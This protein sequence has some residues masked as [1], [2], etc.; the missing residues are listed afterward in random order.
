MFG[1]YFW[2]NLGEIHSPA[3]LTLF[4]F[5]AFSTQSGQKDNSH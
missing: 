2:T 4:E 5:A 3:S 1:H